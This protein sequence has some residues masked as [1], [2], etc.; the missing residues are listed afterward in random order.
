MKKV[1]DRKL[2]LI[3]GLTAIFVFLG[4]LSVS[5]Y[6]GLKEGQSL[7]KVIKILFFETDIRLGFFLLNSIIIVTLCSTLRSNKLTI[8]L[9]IPVAMLSLIMLGLN[10]SLVLKTILSHFISLFWIL[11][12][13]FLYQNKRNYKE[14]ESIAI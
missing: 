8:N 10:L 7:I 12:L 4:F 5:V 2:I 13:I 9:F 6:F 1:V 14:K 3:A 11:Y